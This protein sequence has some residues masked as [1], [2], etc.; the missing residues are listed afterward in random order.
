MRYLAFN[1][2]QYLSENEQMAIAHPGQWQWIAPF[3]SPLKEKRI[4]VPKNL[5]A[6]HRRWAKVRGNR[7]APVHREMMLTLRGEAVY[8]INDQCVLRK[9]GTMILLERHDTRDLKGAMH[10]RNFS[11]LWLHFYNEEYMTYYINSCDKNGRYAHQLPMQHNSG[12]SVRL[13]MHAWDQCTTTCDPLCVTFLKSLIVSTLFEILGSTTQKN[14]PE[15]QQE[16][17]VRSIQKY[18]QQ[19]LGENLSLNGLANVAGYSPFFF[20]RIF[21]KHTGQ[22]LLQFI[23]SERLAKAAKLLEHGLTV[24]ATAETI[25][26]S[27]VSYFHQ[28]FKKHTRKTPGRWRQK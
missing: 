9:P 26:F 10:K 20:H 28:F 16:R 14:S 13:M 17:V 27:S 19:H 11:C 3:F 22:T 24:Q 4:Q 1:F 23:H 21:L 15:N 25:G 18:I 12:D 5:Y 2:S 8:S 7:H 6:R